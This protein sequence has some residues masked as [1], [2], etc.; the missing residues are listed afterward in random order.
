MIKERVAFFRSLMVV[1]D[2]V[3]VGAA[4]V[5]GFLLRDPI[6]EPHSFGYYLWLPPF[7]LA[8]WAALLQ[9]FGTYE[10]FR[11]KTPVEFCYLMLKAAFVG[12]IILSGIIFTFHDAFKFPPV[13]ND[14]I[15]FIFLIA[16]GFLIIEKILLINVF[17]FFR[18]R[19]LNYRIILIVGTGPR[20]QRFIELVQKHAE[21]GLK[22]LGLIDEDPAKVG[23]SFHGCQVIGSFQNFADIIHH[24]VVDQVVFVVPR[25][26]MNRIEDLIS[27]SEIEG[28]K[29]TLAIDFF[30][31]KISR[32]RQTDIAGFPLITFESAPSQLWPLAV[33]RV[34]DVIVSGVGL[35]VL[36]PVFLVL[37]LI[38]KLTS[39]G[40]VYFCQQRS[41]LYSRKFKLFKFRTMVANAED[42]LKELLAKNEMQGPVFK[43]TNDPRVTP[44]G[45]FLRKFSL[46]E[47]PQLWNVFKGEMSIIGPR[48][49]LP[50]EVEK[51]EPWQRRRLSMRPGITCIWQAGGR[52]KITSFD[53][54]MKLDLEYID[55]WSLA[56]DIKLLLKTVPAVLFAI[57]AK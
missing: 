45:R 53:E 10:S 44:I 29:V 55:N 28:L 24:N 16:A 51:Y 8:I 21:W 41:G 2:I 56:L 32:V 40:P 27:L 38:I 46:D 7:I 57:G 39:P 52:N 23:Q 18:K 5:L 1:A 48:P 54:W 35:I 26:W 6:S 15:S 12:F 49:P 14:F 4:C 33:K 42:K 19:G 25:S 47:L 34:F 43:L 31:F 17:R 22:I 9:Y 11:T 50:S 30:N 13:T 3:I 20:A 37:A 36:A